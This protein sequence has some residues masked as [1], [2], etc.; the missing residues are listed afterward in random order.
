MFYQAKSRAISAIFHRHPSPE[1]L[2][3]VRHIS[4]DSSPQRNNLK[5]NQFVANSSTI[6]S[7]LISPKPLN[8]S[9]ADQAPSNSMI[10]NL[11]N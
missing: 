10:N 11:M 3:Q 6:V 5:M 9:A 7:S 4:D 1:E 8:F 2:K